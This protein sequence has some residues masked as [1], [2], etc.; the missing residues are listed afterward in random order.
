MHLIC[1]VVLTII[2]IKETCWLLYACWTSSTDD[3]GGFLVILIV[4]DFAARFG[5]AA[6]RRLEFN[7]KQPIGKPP[8]CIMFDAIDADRSGEPQKGNVEMLFSFCYSICGFQSASSCAQKVHRISI[9][10]PWGFRS[11]RQV[12]TKQKV[13]QV[14]DNWSLE[15][16]TT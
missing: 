2:W 11:S 7:L 6:S 5:S 14:K 1:F 3:F 15:K 10:V 8:R 4:V 13:L 16:Q 9:M 12:F